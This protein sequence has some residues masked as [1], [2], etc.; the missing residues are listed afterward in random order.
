VIKAYLGEEDVEKASDDTG[1][2]ATPAEAGSR[3]PWQAPSPG[4]PLSRE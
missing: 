1:I 2:I 3:A 4:F